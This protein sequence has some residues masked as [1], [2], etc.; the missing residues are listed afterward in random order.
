MDILQE[1]QDHFDDPYHRGSADLATHASEGV[2]HDTDC[3]LRVELAIDEEGQIREAWWDG[4]GCRFCEGTA[5]LLAERL[6]GRLAAELQDATDWRLIYEAADAAQAATCD[7]AP[8]HG[9]GAMVA[10]TWLAAIKSPLAALDEDL[11]DGQQFGGPS[12]REEC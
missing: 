2:N 12:L 6:E 9:C 10:D 4:E 11:A 7:V 8:T 3:H 5:S 1:L